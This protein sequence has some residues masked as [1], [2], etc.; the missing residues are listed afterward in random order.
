MGSV[1]GNLLLRVIWIDYKKL[2]LYVLEWFVK[3]V[4]TL[5]QVE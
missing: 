3:I 1:V 4:I 2:K 5:T